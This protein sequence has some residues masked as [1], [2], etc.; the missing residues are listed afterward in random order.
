MVLLA[1]RTTRSSSTL[2]YKLSF[3]LFA[4]TKQIS[5]F[6]NEQRL[7]YVPFNQ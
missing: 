4:S 3:A 1:D 2:F 6:C 7:Q 5:L